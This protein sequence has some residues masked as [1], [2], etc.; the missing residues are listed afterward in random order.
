MNSN[1]NMNEKSNVVRGEFRRGMLARVID[2]VKSWNERRVAI[3]Q[4]SALSD[5]M[6]SDIGIDRFEISS[7]VR[8]QGSFVSIGTDRPDQSTESAEIREAA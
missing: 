4:L 7:V 8:Q 6:L 2:Q 1:V 5:R 3:R